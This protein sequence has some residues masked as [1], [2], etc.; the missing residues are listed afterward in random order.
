MSSDWKDALGALRT[1]VPEDNTPEPENAPEKATQKGCL[2]IFF[3]RKGRKGK[4]ATIIEDFT[5]PDSEVEEI[6]R[7]MKQRLG[8]G[9]SCRDGEILLQGDQREGA[10]EFLSSL[11]FKCK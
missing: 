2:H 4:A 7:K 11:G 5:I 1:T 3:D 9:G 10:A 8:V 6:A